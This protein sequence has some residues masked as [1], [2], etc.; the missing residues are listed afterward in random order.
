MEIREGI[1]YEYDPGKIATV[2]KD[3]NSKTKFHGL[4]E[5]GTTSTNYLPSS[6]RKDFKSGQIKIIEYPY[7]VG[8]WVYDIKERYTISPWNSPRIAQIT[9]IIDN[10]SDHRI[11][12][13]NEIS[14][15]S[16]KDFNLK[17]RPCF[18]DEIPKKKSEK[19]V[20]EDLTYLG[21]FLK[22]LNIN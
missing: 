17:Y 5:D 12:I 2:I 7:E 9:Q 21:K 22:D 18:K 11:Y 4:F 6:W 14:G 8:D 3:S 19:I 15:L 16:F 10:E 20:K 13:N 1:K